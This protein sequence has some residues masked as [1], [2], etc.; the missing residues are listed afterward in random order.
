MGT[1]GRQPRAAVRGASEECH[2]QQLR[3]APRRLPRRPHLHF[4]RCRRCGAWPL[5]PTVMRKMVFWALA[6][7]HTMPLFAAP[8]NTHIMVYRP[9]HLPEMQ[10]QYAGLLH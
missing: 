7:V 2:G 10:Q 6:L 1:G 4:R 8:N 9:Q 3:L 5:A